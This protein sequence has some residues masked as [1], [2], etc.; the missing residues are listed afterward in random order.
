MAREAND[1]EVPGGDMLPG[2]HYSGHGAKNETSP[3]PRLIGG[4]LDEKLHSV[5]ERGH[6]FNLVA[7]GYNKEA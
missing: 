2:T 5:L 4:I 7:K 3:S 6:L 1:E